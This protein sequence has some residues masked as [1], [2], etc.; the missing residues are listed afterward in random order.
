MVK[1]ARTK[2]SQIW[3]YFKILPLNLDLKVP[4]ESEIHEAKENDDSI[5]EISISTIKSKLDSPEKQQKEKLDK[6]EKI[7]DAHEGLE[8]L[9]FENML[10][11]ILSIEVKNKN[12]SKFRLRWN[13]KDF[14]ILSIFIFSIKKPQNL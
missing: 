11:T 8:D 3:L 9:E 10:F 6:L 4:K 14:S 5:G 12:Q 2:V 7:A 1:L 13:F